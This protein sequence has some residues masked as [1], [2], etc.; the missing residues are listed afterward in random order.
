MVLDLGLKERERERWFL[1]NERPSLNARLSR[2]PLEL[3]VLLLFIS[4]TV[5][6]NCFRSNEIHCTKAL[7]L[8][9]CSHCA[10][11]FAAQE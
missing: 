1:I 5:L 4:V 11:T 3:K 2:L 9:V 8:R 10:V 7:V 6:I